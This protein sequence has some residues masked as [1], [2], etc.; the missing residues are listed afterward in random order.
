MK[1]DFD[2]KLQQTQKLIMTPELKQA[3][4]ILQLNAIELNDLIENE[5]ETNPV[6]EKDDIHDEND[7]YELY[8]YIKGFNDDN[9]YGYN[10]DDEEKD[11]V[12]Y[13][14]FISLKPTMVEHLLFQ[15]H[16]TPVSEKLEKICEYIIFSLSPSGYLKESIKDIALYLGCSEKDVLKALKIVQSFDPPG[17]GARD[18]KECL[19]LQLVAS[20]KYNELVKELIENYLNEIAENKYALLSK[21]LNVSITEIQSAV[22]LI[23]KLNPKP[24]SNFAANNDVK[25]IVP[26]VFVIKRDGEY[27]VIMNDSLFPKLKFNSHYQQIVENSD[28]E[29]AKRYISSKL[30][31]AMWLIKSIESRRETLYKVVKAI[32]DLQKEFFDKGIGYL[33]PMTQ[34]QVADIVGVHESTV[35]RAA[36]GKYVETPR[37]LFEIKYFFQSGISNKN[38]HELSSESIKNLIKKL[39]EEENSQKPLSD[40]KIADILNER[41][42]N[43]SRRTVTKYREELGIASTSK[44]RRF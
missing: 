28:D 7:I 40:Q 34:K 30:Q 20:G 10:K 18:L 15:L 8:K 14:N 3:I 36:N 2:L 43:I 21:K 42:I 17:I 24:G 39:I 26:D 27:V 6:L 31:S 1:M 9:I 13:E 22:D 25:Y 38:G 44:R 32:V 41:D 16:I 12:T 4:E 33:R 35:S 11:E 19:K 5:I 29:V 23:K 37:G